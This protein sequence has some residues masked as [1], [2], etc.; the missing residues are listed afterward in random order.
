MFEKFYSEPEIDQ[1]DIIW[2][3]CYAEMRKSEIQELKERIGRLEEINK[4][5]LTHLSLK[6][7]EGISL[8]KLN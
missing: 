6:I 5:L 3:K 7:D 2:E 8:H 4:L 1:N